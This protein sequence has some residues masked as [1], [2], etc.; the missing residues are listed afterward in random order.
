MLDE[1]VSK[2]DTQRTRGSSDSLASM[3]SCASDESVPMSY[4]IVGAAS[5]EASCKAFWYS[6]LEK[7]IDSAAGVLGSTVRYSGT[8]KIFDS[9]AVVFK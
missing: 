2:R 4:S 3:R 6:G 8:R 1:F 7:T 9:V 5:P